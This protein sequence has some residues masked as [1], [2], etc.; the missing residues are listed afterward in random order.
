MDHSKYQ[1]GFEA[2]KKN[3]GQNHPLDTSS[4][5]FNVTRRS[6]GADPLTIE[7]GG[8]LWQGTITV[9]T[10]AVSY[11]VD[12]DTGS[13]DLFLPGPSCV[14]DCAGHRMYNPASS[15]TAVDR[16]QTFKLSYGDGSSVS[17]E[18][19]TDTVTIAGLTVR[20]NSSIA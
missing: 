2:Y 17:G 6:T 4:G 7:H 12:F 1:T 18:Q 16:K 15:S 10:P 19:Y 5:V 3:T 9:G 13:S 14:I 20:C 8:Q 11:T